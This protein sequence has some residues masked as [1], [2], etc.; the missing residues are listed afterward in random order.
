MTTN[1][2]RSNYKTRLL[3]VNYVYQYLYA[4]KLN[5]SQNFKPY[6]KDLTGCNFDIYD[7]VTKS[8]RHHFNQ[9]YNQIIEKCP[10]IDNIALAVLCSYLAEINLNYH[11]ELIGDF[12][13]IRRF[14]LHVAW[15]LGSTKSYGCVDY[16][17]KLTTNST[18]ELSNNEFE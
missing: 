6:P 16:F 13:H 18:K 14:Y 8:A 12:K 15:V 1:F 9:N 2:Y 10:S 5:Y 17:I 4:F 3:I 7:K 11:K